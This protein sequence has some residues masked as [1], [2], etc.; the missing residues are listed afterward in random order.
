MQ[1]M[2]FVFLSLFLWLLFHPTATHANLKQNEEG[3]KKKK[4][5]KTIVNNNNNR[6][7]VI[8]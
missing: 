1:N 5:K 2:L 7:V 4:E 6:N 8:G 3:R